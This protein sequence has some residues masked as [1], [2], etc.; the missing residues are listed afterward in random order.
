MPEKYST[1]A[2]TLTGPGAFYVTGEDNLRVVLRNSLASAVVTIEG[3]FL[4]LAGVVTPFVEVI[5]PA[6]DR[7]A[8]TRDFRLGDGW[9]LNVSARVTTGAPAVGQVYAR[10]CVIRGL[11]AAPI[12]IGT[13]VQG[14][15]TE[16]DDLAWP[17]GP[18]RT[19]VEGPGW[20][21]QMTVTA[22]AEGEE[23]IVIVPTGARWRPL[24]FKARLV[25]SGTAANREASLRITDGTNI[26]AYVPSGTTQTASLTRTYTWFHTTG[27]GA[28]SVSPGIIAPFPRM[29]L[30]AGMQIETNTLAMDTTD[31][32]SQ[33]TLVVEEWIEG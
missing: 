6:S 27:R 4:T 9:I 33:V 28:G 1:T 3:R 8:V 25:S 17:G 13:L 7:T 18:L 5:A 30:A 15:A 12:Q 11:G 2:P 23:V 10:I 22:P 26:F 29:D 19:S 32:W 14:Y 16:A 31:Q 21:R 24:T 20:I